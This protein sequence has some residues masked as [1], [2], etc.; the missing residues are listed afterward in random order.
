[1]EIQKALVAGCWK[2]VIVLSGGA[3]EAVLLDRAL[4]NEAQAKGSKKAPKEQPSPKVW[5]VGGAG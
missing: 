1:M 4:A 5:D 2:A 3:L